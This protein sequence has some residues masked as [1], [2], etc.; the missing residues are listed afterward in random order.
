MTGW[1]PTYPLSVAIIPLIW[2]IVQ[3]RHSGRVAYPYALD[4]MLPRAVS[5]GG[6]PPHGY[7]APE[8]ARAPRAARA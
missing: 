8:A 1:A 6:A 4:I 5:W 7:P 2:W 3:R